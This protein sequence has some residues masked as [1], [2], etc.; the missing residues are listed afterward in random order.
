MKKT[1]FTVDLLNAEINVSIDLK[2]NVKI[3]KGGGSLL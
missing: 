3:G 1:N 2:T